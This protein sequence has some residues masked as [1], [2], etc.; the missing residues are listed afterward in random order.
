VNKLNAD[1]GKSSVEFK[2][3]SI[4]AGSLRA[5]I[6]TPGNNAFYCPLICDVTSVDTSENDLRIEYRCSEPEITAILKFKRISAGYSGTVTL[7]GKGCAVVRFV[8]ELPTGKRG[9]PFV[10]AFMYGF[11]EGGKSPDAT[12]P[13]LDS[14][15]N[16]AG[17]STP[18]VSDQ[19][20]VRADRSSHGLT[21]V[22]FDEITCAIG[23]RDVCRYHNGDVAEKNG[24]GISS[25]N[26]H[27]LS[28]LLGFQNVPYTYS[29]VPGRNFVTRPDGYA[30]LDK[31][32]VE[33]E[34][35]LFCFQNENRSQAAARLLRE[36]Y[37]LLHDEIGNAGTV[38]EA[39]T[40]I[41]D[42]LVE[43]GYCKE[44][45][46]FHS[47][48]VD[49]GR[50]NSRVLTEKFSSGWSGGTRSA[51]PL[52][53]AG[54]QFNKSQWIEPARHVLSNIAENAMHEKSGLFF[55]NYDLKKDRWDVRGWWYPLLE[56]PGHSGY[57][58]GH[59]CY[60]LL[61]GYQT[62]RDNGTEY[63][64]WLQAARKVLDH[65]V[66]TRSADN[67]FGYTYHEETGAILDDVGFAG[68]WF[69]PALVLLYKISDESKYLQLAVESVNAY[70]PD[71]CQFDVYGSPHD[72]W[73]SPDEE[74][75]LAWVKAARLLHEAT[76][77]QQFLEDL[78]LGLDFEFSWKFA[79]NVVNEIEPLK[80]MDWCSTG[81][82]VTSVNN[83]HIHPMGSSILPDILY[84]YEQT[85]DVYYQSRFEDTL[86]WTLTLYLHHDGH[87]GWGKKGMINE[88]FCYTD[89]L[90]LER[91]PDGSPSS[92]WFCGHSWASGAVLEGLAGPIAERAQK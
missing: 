86:R 47:T 89:S 7:S 73:K 91:F 41:A 87:Y 72:I 68:C 32:S 58:N 10:P 53:V 81:G 67:R 38:E 16:N 49:P 15:S 25:T 6:I 34:L 61:S 77:Q 3:G 50:K 80:S 52:L 92:T 18:W 42:R 57:V 33:S 36:S 84:A 55:E 28:F 51:L 26:P 13:Q 70:R 45:G 37:A 9:F 71:V 17:F 19:W 39:I 30:D 21:S 60:Y 63:S 2:L 90:L 1:H 74:G 20:L 83:S 65:V 29:T 31:G 5:Y 88:R 75:I 12:Y 43:S 82:S 40:V 27:R 8:W 78:L 48:L 54:H 66:R 62:E 35:F 56:N 23:G 22:I 11:N 4:V 24:L 44:A 59:I 46:N 64:R 79:Y 14:G 69:I 76:G 85:G